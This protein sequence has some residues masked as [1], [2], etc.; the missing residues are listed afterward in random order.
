MISW[1]WSHRSRPAIGSR[2][3]C[4]S[5]AKRLLSLAALVSVNCRVATLRRRGAKIGHRVFIS[6]ADIQGDLAHLSIGDATFIGRVQVQVVADVHIGASVCINDGARLL[7]ASHSTSDPE[8][9]LVAKPILIEDH[10]W[11]ATGAIIL[12]GVTI[13]H[14]A[15]IGAGAVVGRDVPPFAVMVGNPARRTN[16]TRPHELRYDPVKLV[17]PFNAWLS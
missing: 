13:G 12:P 9:S 17:A 6:R 4:K 15:V 10:V 8:W 11:I 16:R 3:W 7:S 5:W 1:L 14:G 2:Q